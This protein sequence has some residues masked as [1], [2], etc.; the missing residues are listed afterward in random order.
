MEALPY[1]LGPGDESSEWGGFSDGCSDSDS[2]SEVGSD[3]DDS[4]AEVTVLLRK[5][6]M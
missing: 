2:D 6:W 4:G 1:D 3:H 5:P